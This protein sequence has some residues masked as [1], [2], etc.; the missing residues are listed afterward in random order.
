MLRVLEVNVDDHLHGGVYVLVKNI[1]ENLP[2][3]ITA[4]IAALEPFDDYK[5]ITE[6]EQ[7]GSSVYYVGSNR[8]KI[9]KQLDIYR[10]IKR[11][12]K[13]NKYDVVHLHSDVSHK[14]LV[15][16]LASKK[17]TKCLI[18]H[19][20][21]S[22]AEGGHLA[23][24]RAFHRLCCFFLKRIPAIYVATSFDA[25]K[26]MFPWAKNDEVIILDNG[27]DYNRFRYDEKKRKEKREELKIDSVIYLIGLFGRF[28]PAK[29]PMYSIK[30]LESLLKQDKNIRL[31]CIGEGP[32]KKDFVKVLKEK[33][34]EQY[35]CFISNTDSIEEY[36][37]AIDALIMP[38]N[39]EGFGLVAVESQI[40][41]TPTIVSKNVPEKTN[42]S[43]LIHYLPIQEDAVNQWSELLLR[44]RSY[45]KHDVSK[46]IDKR[47]EIQILVEKLVEIYRNR[48]SAYRK[49]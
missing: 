30:I 11:I 42:I 44:E 26:W 47:Y 41:G 49:I 36:Y 20:H 1:I 38:S 45:V 16:A 43:E 13:K 32:L 27:I 33:A 4:D 34:L 17:E 48:E 21:A 9:L 25:G 39:F 3:D 29:N 37:Q 46:K 7:Y 35:V 31:L 2:N 18:F 23:V 28:V 8:N 14:I 19:S 22:D 15:S 5:H 6:F 40:S 10:N 12:V 24:R